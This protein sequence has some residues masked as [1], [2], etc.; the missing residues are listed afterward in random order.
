M[1]GDPSEL[2]LGRSFSF[3]AFLA[4]LLTAHWYSGTTPGQINKKQKINLKSLK[5]NNRN[6]ETRLAN[7]QVSIRQWKPLLVPINNWKKK[8]T[9]LKP[10]V[11]PIAQ[12]HL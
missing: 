6:D 11:C 2:E 12:T 9:E 3:C 4:S 5:K 10:D 8:E 7:I 1:S